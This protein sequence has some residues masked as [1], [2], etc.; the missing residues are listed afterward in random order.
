MAPPPSLKAVSSPSEAKP[1]PQQT[2]PDPRKLRKELVFALIGTSSTAAG[3]AERAGAI[4]KDAE[5]LFAY[6]M[7][8]SAPEGGAA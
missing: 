3:K 7:E 6:I 4:I 1:P 8:G 5:R 2:P